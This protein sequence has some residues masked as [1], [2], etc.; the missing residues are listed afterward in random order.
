MLS[1]FLLVACAQVAS[2]APG[3]WFYADDGESI[4]WATVHYRGPDVAFRTTG[5]GLAS[6]PVSGAERL[7]CGQ[8]TRATL[9]FEQGVLTEV[10]TVPAA[11]CVEA[12]S[13]AM[14][15]ATLP[16]DG[17]ALGERQHAIVVYDVPA[18]ATC[19]S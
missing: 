4:E 5:E 10:V 3:N 9:I 2:P 17:R 12:A 1:L 15:W 6:G 14:D 7:A 8:A 11:A 19:F 16:L 13:Q 18:E